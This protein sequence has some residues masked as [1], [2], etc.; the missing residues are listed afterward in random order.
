MNNFNVGQ[1]ALC[2]RH[3]AHFDVATDNLFFDRVGEPE[4]YDPHVLG[5]RLRN[6]AR[7]DLTRKQ[8]ILAGIAR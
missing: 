6:L 1:M 7:M 2:N 5:K 4:A 8:R 3:K